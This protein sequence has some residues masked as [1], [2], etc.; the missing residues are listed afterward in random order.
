MIPSYRHWHGH[1]RSWP[2]EPL[3]A[4]LALLYQMKIGKQYHVSE[5][6]VAAVS[7]GLSYATSVHNLACWCD[8]GVVRMTDQCHVEVVPEER[9]GCPTTPPSASI[10][11]LCLCFKS[12][13]H[14]MSTGDKKWQNGFTSTEVLWVWKLETSR[15]KHLQEHRVNWGSG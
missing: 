4:Y 15:K 10:P 14:D 7:L 6:H 5:I 12:I 8:V 1:V 2:R 3:D 9:A 13:T 11:V